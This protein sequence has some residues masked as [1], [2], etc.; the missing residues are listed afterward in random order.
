M[1]ISAVQIQILMASGLVPPVSL[2]VHKR[3]GVT[4]QLRR[5]STPPHLEGLAKFYSIRSIL[6]GRRR[7]GLQRR[8]LSDSREP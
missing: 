2:D 1:S 6:S 8:R 3:G 5:V 4:P 7:L